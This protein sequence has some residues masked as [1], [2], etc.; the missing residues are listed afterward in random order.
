MPRCASSNEA[1][2]GGGG[3]R[4][5][6]AHVAEELRL[7][8]GLR[9]RAAVHGDERPLA[10]RAG[11]VDGLGDDLLAGARLAGDEHGGV[12]GGDPR[13]EIEDPLHLG[14]AGHD[15]AGAE[16]VA[17]LPAQILV[18]AAERALVE[19]P[20]DPMEELIRLPPLL[21]VVEGA[22]PDG[23]LRRFPAGIG[24]QEDDIGIGPG[25]LDRPQHLEAVAVGH[26][27]IGHDEVE[28]VLG[29]ALEGLGHALGLGD[30]MATLAQEQSEGAPR[31][32][33][34]VHDQDARQR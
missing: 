9:Q 33:L 30:A 18:L 16:P 7:E 22:E 19:G 17:H 6:A 8:Q 27:E 11:V 34:V 23:L 14:R 13:H 15:A 5:R 4:E 20:I 31:R 28:G 3:A 26:A 1:A 25:G 21:E 32:G 10:P 24:G 2:L 12:G 29:E